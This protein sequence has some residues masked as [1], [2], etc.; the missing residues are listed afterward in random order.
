MTKSSILR[1][2]SSS[3]LSSSFS[4]VT[5]KHWLPLISPFMFTPLLSIEAPLC[6]DVAGV[7]AQP[8]HPSQVPGMFDF[9]TAVH[10]N[11]YSGLFGDVRAFQTDDAELQPDRAGSRCD[12]ITGNAR[13]GVG[14]A[15]HV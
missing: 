10:H 8:V 7:E 14:R 4:G 13:H 5:I 11:L 1:L 9:H 15:K 6:G 12:S 3:T 2:L